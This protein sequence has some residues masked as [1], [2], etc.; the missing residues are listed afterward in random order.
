MSSPPFPSRKSSVVP[1]KQLS[2]AA[3]GTIESRDFQ[4][5]RSV[6]NAITIEV[7]AA[8]EESIVIQISIVTAQLPLGCST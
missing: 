3:E 2:L 8:I 5:I 7:F 6:G 1:P 4:A